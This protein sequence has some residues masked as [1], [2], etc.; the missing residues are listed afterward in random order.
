MTNINQIMQ[1]AKQ[2]QEKMEALQAQLEQMEVDGQSG[3]GMVTTT[4]TLK[5]QV[6]KLSIEPGV[7]NADDKEMLEDLIMAALNDAR[8]KADQKLAEETQKM[9]GS[10]G[11]PG[12]M[13][14]PF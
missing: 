7:I 13:Q 2:M 12:N 9:M 1:Q 10:M 6:R 8:A 14:L 3:G 5:G 11:L 4:I